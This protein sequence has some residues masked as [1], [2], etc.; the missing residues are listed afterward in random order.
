MQWIR[1]V[2]KRTV[3]ALGVVAVFSVIVGTGLGVVGRYFE[4]SNLTWSFELTAMGF[5]WVTAL[6]TLLA[7]VEHENVALDMIDH[8]VGQRGAL[9]L[10]VLRA[11]ILLA[12]GVY[13]LRSGIAQLERTAFSPTPVMRAP[14]WIVHVSIPVLGSGLAIIAF[15]RLYKSL[16]ESPQNPLRFA[17]RNLQ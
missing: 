3:S 16:K 2:V 4:L 8:K 15:A 14:Q 10:N 13:L 17:G 1:D 11:A 6:G 5:I 9:I 7:E 12:I